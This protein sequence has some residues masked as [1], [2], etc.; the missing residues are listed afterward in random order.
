[1]PPVLALLSTV[2]FGLLF[3][4][5]GVLLAAPL[6]LL[7]IVTLEVLYV[8]QGLGDPPE[9]P[10]SANGVLSREDGMEPIA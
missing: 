10:L 2:A 4:P 5:L 7:L 6:T 8:Q 1:L 9:D 3:G